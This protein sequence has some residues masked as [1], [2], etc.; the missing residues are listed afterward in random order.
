MEDWSWRRWRICW[1]R[2]EWVVAG[3]EEMEDLLEERRWGSMGLEVQSKLC[4]VDETHGSTSR[5]AGT[6]G[7]MAPEYRLHGEFSDKSDVFSFGVLLLEILS[8]QKNNRFRTS[9]NGEDLISYAWESWRDG[10][11]SN[12]IDPTLRANSNS[13][14]EMI[15]RYIHIGLLCVQKNVAERPTMGSVVLMLSSSS[16]TLSDPSEPG[17]F[18]HSI[19]S[20]VP[21]VNGCSY[22]AVNEP[23][24]SVN[25]NT[26]TELDPR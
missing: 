21:V 14:C 7:Y 25:E 11:A 2:G 22:G 3:G 18:L 16:L 19:N 6:P 1:R 23:I 24:Q 26:I 20:E 13:T 9:Q 8:G 12:L 17:S 5:I 15:M 4:A 10:I